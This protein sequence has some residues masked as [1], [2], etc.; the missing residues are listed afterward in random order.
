ML[1]PE[2]DRTTGIRC[3]V[4]NGFS[5]TPSSVL[6]IDDESAIAAS[7]VYFLRPHKVEHAISGRLALQR[8]R[9]KKFDIVLCDLLMP[10]MNGIELYQAVTKIWPC[11]H[12]SFVFMTGGATS[13]ETRLFLENTENIRVAKP[14]SRDEI[15]LAIE[16]QLHRP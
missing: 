6:V 4:P 12:R 11:L 2:N 1:P 10:E 14:F 5:I 15:M 13:N 9:S 7:M 3:A 8:L 16:T